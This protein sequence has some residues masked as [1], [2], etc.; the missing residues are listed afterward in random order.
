MPLRKADSDAPEKRQD[1]VGFSTKET[2]T[3]GK[4][5]LNNQ[6]DFNHLPS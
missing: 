6:M 3:R 1:V 2:G 4:L 5:L